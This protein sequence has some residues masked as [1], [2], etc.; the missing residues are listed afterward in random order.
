M[1]TCFLY[2]SACVFLVLC[3]GFSLLAP[4]CQNTS[5]LMQAVYTCSELRSVSDFLK[6]M[7]R[8]QLHPHLTFVVRDSRL[9]KIP[10]GF[11]EDVNATVLEFS[12]V[13]VGEF[14]PAEPSSFAGLEDTLE[15]IIFR[16]GSSLPRAWSALKVLSQLKILRLSHMKNLN[17]S[18]DM[19]ELSAS[20]LAV[21][22]L[23]SSIVHIDEGWLAQISGLESLVVRDC[24]LRVFLRSMLPRPAPKLW[25]LDLVLNNITQLPKDFGQGLPALKFLDLESNQITSIEEE[26]LAPLL[27]SNVEAI[28]LGDNPLHCDCELRH[29]RVFPERVLSAT[30][31]TPESIRRRKVH[32]LT[33]VE[34]QCD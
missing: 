3:P 21:E 18:R 19:N 25:N 13:T 9:E 30:C 22:V 12:N 29:L 7:E 16:D 15:K 26:C 2:S 23:H 24:N 34:L 6:H 14:D 33:D 20:L 4:M 17:L 28:E 31:S 1:S 5:R 27:T 8:P 32:T 11:F 10:S